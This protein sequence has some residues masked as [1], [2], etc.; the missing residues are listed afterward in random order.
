MSLRLRVLVNVTDLIFTYRISKYQMGLKNTI[1][2]AIYS[3]HVMLN[4]LL[5]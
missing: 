5:W 1:A 3:N 2:C 4:E